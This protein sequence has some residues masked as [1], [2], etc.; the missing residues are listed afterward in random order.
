MVDPSDLPAGKYHEFQEHG[1]RVLRKLS[2]GRAGQPESKTLSNDEIDFAQEEL[3]STHGSTSLYVAKSRSRPNRRF[4]LKE[5]SALPSDL[6]DKIWAVRSYI[7]FPADLGL[8]FLFQRFSREIAFWQQLDHPNILPFYGVLPHPGP[9]PSNVLVTPWMEH[10]NADIYVK[11]NP[12]A[13][14]LAIVSP[15]PPLPNIEQDPCTYVP[16]DC[17]NGAWTQ[18]PTRMLSIHPPWQ[19]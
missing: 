12:A 1:T 3:V 7:S 2:R 8:T 5:M 19:P 16:T 10:G 18:L 15:P 14:R 4:A 17:T 9:D 6:T 11:Q 13:S